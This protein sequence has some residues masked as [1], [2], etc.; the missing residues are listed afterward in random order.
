MIE[1]DRIH[2]AKRSEVVFEWIVVAMPSHHIERGVLGTRF[3]K[4]VLKF[5]YNLIAAVAIRRKL[6]VFVGGGW[7]LEV[8]GVCQAVRTDRS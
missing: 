7:D 1:R 2:T 3:E 4:F 5:L 8:S 6:D